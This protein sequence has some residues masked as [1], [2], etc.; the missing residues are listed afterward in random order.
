LPAL[1]LVEPT[2]ELL[3]IV[4]ESTA[5]KSVLEVSGNLLDR[6]KGGNI[7]GALGGGET[8]LKTIALGSIEFVEEGV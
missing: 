1:E 5:T 3:F 7:C 2:G 4:A 6:E 8:E